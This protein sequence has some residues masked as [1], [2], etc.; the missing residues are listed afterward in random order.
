MDPAKAQTPDGKNTFYWGGAFGTWF[1]IDPTNDLIVVGMMQ[2]LKGS[3]PTGGSP[4]VRPLACRLVYQALV[5]P[6]K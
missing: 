1:W 3:A 5:D 4:R 2:N 6:T